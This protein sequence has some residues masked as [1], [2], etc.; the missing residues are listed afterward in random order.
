M[1]YALIG[2]NISEKLLKNED[3]ETITM[4]YAKNGNIPPKE[5]EHDPKI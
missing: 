5:W 4:I 2:N 1:H 3:G